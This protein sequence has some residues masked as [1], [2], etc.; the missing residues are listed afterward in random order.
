MLNF[1]VIYDHW[2]A[3]FVVITIRSFGHS[4]LISEECLPV[5]STRVHTGFLLLWML[6]RPEYKSSY[7]TLVVVNA[8]PSRVHEFIL[9]SCC[10]ECLPVQ[11]TRV[12]TGLLLLWMPT[13]PEYKSSYR[14]LVVV[15][16]YPSR[17]QEFILGSCCC[18]CLPV[19][20]TRVHTGLLLL[21]MPTRPEYKSSYRVFVARSLASC[22]M[23]CRSLFVLFLLLLCCLSFD[24]PLLIIPLV[25][26]NYSYWILKHCSRKRG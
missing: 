23:F 22:V 24:L 13:R 26:S 15:N 14:A 19:Q 20:S 11:S 17:V 8:Y 18:E 21:W 2:Y 5:Q 10:C 6:T 16:A 4:W 1:Y 12:H 7:R 9:G 3:P 25:S